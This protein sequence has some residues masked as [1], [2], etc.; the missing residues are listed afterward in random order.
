M[1]KPAQHPGG[2]K[3]PHAGRAYAP[4]TIHKVHTVLSSI[5]SEAVE[6]RM[7]PMNPCHGL[8]PGGKFLQPGRSNEL[9]ARAMCPSGWPRRS[10][11]N[12]PR[13]CRRRGDARRR[14]L[15]PPARPPELLP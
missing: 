13:P 3:N 5:M 2:R 4:G 15:L 8:N 1:R 9:D 7:L 11:L 12:S 14:W 6:R 10:E